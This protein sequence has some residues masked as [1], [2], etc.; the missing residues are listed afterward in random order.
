MNK[1]EFESDLRREGYEV[2]ED[3]MEPNMHRAAHA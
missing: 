1:A 2:H 3:G